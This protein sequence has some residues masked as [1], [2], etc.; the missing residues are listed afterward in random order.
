MY[1]PAR[2][3]VDLRY[4]RFVPIRGAVKAE[5]I[6]EFKNIFNSVQTSGVN[7]ALRVLPTGELAPDVVIPTDAD[8]FP[9]TSGYEQR[10]FQLGFKV[11][12]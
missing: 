5:I 3:N 2:Y 12:F 11:R 8:G 1:L 4:S 9:A 6:G 7:S 10:Q